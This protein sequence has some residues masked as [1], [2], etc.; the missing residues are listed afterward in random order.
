MSL[1]QFDKNTY[2][3]RPS[4]ETKGRNPSLKNISEVTTTQVLTN[5]LEASVFSRF[6]SASVISQPDGYTKLID[7]LKSSGELLA[8]IDALA[9]DILSDGHEFIGNESNIKIADEFFEKNNLDLTLYKWLNDTFLY[10]NGFLVTNFITETQIKSVMD[11]YSAGFETKEWNDLS[12]E[13]KEYADEVAAKNISIQHLPAS[14]VSIFALDKYGNNILYKQKVGI[15]E[16]NFSQKQVIHLK[17]IDVDGK[18]WG[19]SRLYSIK[20]ELQTLAFIKDYYGLYFENNAT[21]DKLFIAKQM[22]YGTPEHKDAVLQLQEMKKPGNRRKNMLVLSDWEVKDL[23]TNAND[24]QFENLWKTIISLIAMTFEMPASRYGGTMNATAEEATLSNQGY[25]RNISSWQDKIE[26]V[27]NRQLFKP[28][29]DVEIKF[30]RNYKEDEIREVTILKTM[31]D[32]AEQRMRMKLWTREAAANFLKIKTEEMPTDEEIA[33]E[34]EELQN[35]YMQGQ[36]GKNEKVDE[37]VKNEREN[38]TPK[39]KTKSNDKV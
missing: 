14:T 8:I 35:Q 27:L 33:Q 32:I 11:K 31:S 20:S 4:F 34:Q 39:N 1:E 28:V 24:K 18:L 37:H 25:Y 13:L 5:N 21:P 29:F 17:D 36:L 38:H 6:G 3:H 10:G 23:N 12:F 19:Y 30:N 2:I 26:G 16:E 7:Y 22:K 15:E 9:T